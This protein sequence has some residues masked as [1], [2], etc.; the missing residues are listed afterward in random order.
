M[1]IK[2]KLTKVNSESMTGTYHIQVVG[3]K[4][5]RVIEVNID[6]FLMARIEGR[7]R[8]PK[9]FVNQ[10]YENYEF[11]SDMDSS[12]Y[13]DC[14]FV[15]KHFKP[16]KGSNIPEHYTLDTVDHFTVNLRQLIIQRMEDY[17]NVS[18]LLGKYV[19][20]QICEVSAMLDTS[21]K[22][23]VPAKVRNLKA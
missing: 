21:K 13:T 17:D 9:L 22:P 19:R 5:K 16:V 11:E 23:F 12:K 3:E 18:H 14:P 20:E 15:L 6:P 1:R 7:G 10:R 2:T 8:G 4:T